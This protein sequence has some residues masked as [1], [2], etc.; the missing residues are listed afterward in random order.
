MMTEHPAGHVGTMIARE[1][2]RT[3]AHVSAINLSARKWF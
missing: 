1:P 3:A 2:T